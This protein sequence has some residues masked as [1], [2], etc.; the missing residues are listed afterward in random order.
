MEPSVKGKKRIFPV[1]VRQKRKKQR[2]R[3]DYPSLFRYGREGTSEGCVIEIAKKRGRRNRFSYSTDMLARGGEKR[4]RD[5]SSEESVQR[6][7]RAGKDP[8]RFNPLQKEKGKRDRIFPS[9]GNEQG[10]KEERGMRPRSFR[11]LLAPL[12]SQKV[13]HR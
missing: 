3:K 5:H 2:K 4:G 13:F 7:G 9:H 12:L 8:E 11:Q 10:K 6:E 1:N